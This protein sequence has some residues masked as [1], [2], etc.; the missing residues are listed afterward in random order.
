MASWV[1]D[2]SVILAAAAAA[3]AAAT[4]GL[5]YGGGDSVAIVV[6]IWI[7]RSQTK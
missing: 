3:A 1:R 4:W 7:I 5:E 6:D 2:V